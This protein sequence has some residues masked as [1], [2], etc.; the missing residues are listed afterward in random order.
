MGVKPMTAN[1]DLNAQS[2]PAVGRAQV[3]GSG[4]ARLKVFAAAGAEEEFRAGKLVTVRWWALREFFCLAGRQ[5]P[6]ALG[7][8]AHDK[9][10]LG[11]VCKAGAGRAADVYCGVLL[12]VRWQ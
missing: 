2:Y 8:T 7:V 4:G 11:G 1:T 9:G 3:C 12:L 6:C 10:P 5:Q